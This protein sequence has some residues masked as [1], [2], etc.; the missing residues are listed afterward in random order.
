MSITSK[1][2]LRRQWDKIPQNHFKAAYDGLIDRLK[3]I[4]R[5]KAG[6]FEQI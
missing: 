3:A 4:I 6:Q 5:A 2:A 1:K